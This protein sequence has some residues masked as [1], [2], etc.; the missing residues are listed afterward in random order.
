MKKNVMMRVASV[1]MVAVLLT[2]CAISGTFAKYV[3]K[4]EGS[5]I[6]RVAKFGVGIIA[7]GDTFANGY[8]DDKTTSTTVKTNASVWNES[9]DKDLVAPG[10]SGSMAKMTL[11]GTPEVDVRVSYVAEVEISDNWVVGGDTYFPIQI[12]VNGTAVS[13]DATDDIADIETA[14]EDAIKAYSKDYEH[15][16]NLSG[17]AADSLEVTWEW[18][19]STSAANDIKDTK[20]GDQAVD[21]DITVSIAVTTTGTQID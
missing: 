1:L 5:D 2:T 21:E 3:T 17:V 15:N 13:Y 20:L 11:T 19:F 6:A 8:E 7:Y 14:I 12:K 4:A 16:T 10:T 18:P 9:E